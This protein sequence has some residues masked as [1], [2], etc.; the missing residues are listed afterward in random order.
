[1]YRP[2]DTVRSPNRKTVFGERD[3]SASR[4]AVHTRSAGGEA[5]GVKREVPVRLTPAAR[6]IAKPVLASGMRQLPGLR[7]IP[8]QPEV[9][10]GA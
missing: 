9:R 5:G 7:F 10:P 8:D 2:A 6:R 4:S 3:A 1:M